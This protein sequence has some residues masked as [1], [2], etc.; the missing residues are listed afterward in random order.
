[1]STPLEPLQPLTPLTPVGG[2]DGICGPDGC[3]IPAA[4]PAAT[5]KPA[6]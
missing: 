4:H 3:A 2:A 5:A 1:M 6:D